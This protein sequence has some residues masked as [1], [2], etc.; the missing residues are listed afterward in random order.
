MNKVAGYIVHV[1]S[2]E[3][4]IMTGSVIDFDHEVIGYYGFRPNS[5]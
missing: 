3:S 4:G 2:S 5:S 1:A